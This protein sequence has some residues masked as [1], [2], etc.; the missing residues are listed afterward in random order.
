MASSIPVLRTHLVPP[1]LAVLTT[2]WSLMGHAA[3]E[4]LE[5]RSLQMMGAGRTFYAAPV[6][7]DLT[8]GSTPHPWA[9]I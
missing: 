9:T 8:D 4:G 3:P 6:G 7:S 5:D 1:A 2:L